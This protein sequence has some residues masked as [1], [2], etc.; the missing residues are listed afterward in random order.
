MR[1]RRDRGRGWWGAGERKRRDGRRKK[2]RNI[3]LPVT[4]WLSSRTQRQPWALAQPSHT[5]APPLC[6]RF[7][8]SPGQQPCLARMP[9]QRCVSEA[10]PEKRARKEGQPCP[11]AR[12]AW[13]GREAKAVSQ[14]GTCPN[15]GQG[16]TKG[17]QCRGSEGIQNGCSWWRGPFWQAI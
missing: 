17:P 15:W 13:W 6:V 4:G 1:T 3:S 12:P 7:L 16:G 10:P 2:E 11:R 8:K 14:L 9:Q 5:G